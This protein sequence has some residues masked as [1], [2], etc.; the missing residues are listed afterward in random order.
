MKVRLHQ[1][2]DWQLPVPHQQHRCCIYWPLAGL[3]KLWHSTLT[4]ARTHAHTHTFKNNHARKHTD[5]C[6]RGKR[7]HSHSSLLSQKHTQTHSCTLQ[8]N[9]PPPPFPPSCCAYSAYLQQIKRGLILRR[10]ILLDL[11][12]AF[13][14]FHSLQTVFGARSLSAQCG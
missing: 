7:T 1:S 13:S 3:C 11:R 8:K 10:A 14:L 2:G 4:P 9:N 6:M 5:R 12:W